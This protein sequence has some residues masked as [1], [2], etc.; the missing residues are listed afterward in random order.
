MVKYSSKVI[1]K[2]HILSS[3]WYSVTYKKCTTNDFIA[4]VIYEIRW[5]LTCEF[6]MGWNVKHYHSDGFYILSYIM[7]FDGT[8][9]G[10]FGCMF[11][12]SH[13]GDHVCIIVIYRCFSKYTGKLREAEASQRRW[14]QYNWEIIC[15]HELI[16]YWSHLGVLWKLEPVSNG[17]AEYQQTVVTTMNIWV[18]KLSMRI[19]IG[20]ALITY[21]PI[22][23]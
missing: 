7:W 5:R 6:I 12:T 1:W 21:I 3:V 22:Y 4:C 11:F 10:A 2:N 20:C 8:W 18:Y 17:S 14:S 23:S 15:S 19:T 9:T 13:P 16:P